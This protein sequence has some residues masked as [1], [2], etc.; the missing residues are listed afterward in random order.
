[1]GWSSHGAKR[2]PKARSN[3][4]CRPFSRSG[5]T[6]RPTCGSV[7]IDRLDPWLGPTKRGTGDCPDEMNLARKE[8]KSRRRITGLRSKTTKARTHV[9]RLRA[10]NADLKKKLA[11]ALE[12]QTATSEVLQVISSS[13]GE[14]GSVFQAMLENATRICEASFGSMALREGDGFRRVALYNA[15]PEFAEFNEREPYIA[16]GVSSTLDQLMRTKQLVHL[17]V[18]DP[19]TP[20][21]RYAGARTVLAVPLLK[22]DE[23]VGV[24]GI[25]RREVR[26]FTDKQIELVQNFAAQAV[27]AIENTR[28][29]NELRQ[30]TDALRE[31]LDRQT[32]MAEVLGVIS[33]SPG[34]LQPVFETIL[35]NAVRICDAKFGT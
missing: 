35:A 30:G 6:W 21:A 16:P 2:S 25:Y 24:F 3:I 27:I 22:E 8:A 29:L 14:L 19:D 7:R 26:P 32:A 4:D 1:M 10:A 18:E 33:S 23:L 11:E 13:P 34:E 31:S 5:R 12:Q 28:R 15:P 17:P 20:L 9:D